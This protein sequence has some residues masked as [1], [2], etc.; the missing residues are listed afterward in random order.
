[1][2]RYLRAS[3]VAATFVSLLA[4]AGPVTAQSGSAIAGVV[5]DSTGA[6]LPGVT[7]EAASPALIEKVRTSV[8]DGQGVFRIVDLRPGTYSV[9]FTLPGFTTVKREGIELTASFTATV[10]ADMR[11]GSLEETITVTGE[12]STVDVQNVVQQRVMTRDVID[13]IPTGYKSVFNL[14]VLVPGVTAFAHDVGGAS[15]TSN[16]IAIHGSRAGETQLLHDG[17]DYSHG[18]GRGGSFTAIATNDATV[19][20]ISLEFGGISAESEMGG[21]RTNIIPKEGGNTFKGTFSG[22]FTNS[23]LQSDNLSDELQAMGLTSTTRT[24]SVYDI[25]PA[26]GGPLA[27]DKVWFF[28]SW[29][30]WASEQTVAGRYFN[31]TPD[32]IPPR[33]TPDLDRPGENNEY[34]RNESLRLT[35]Q[36]TPKNKVSFQ[37]QYGHRDIPGYGY[38]LNRNTASPEAIDANRSIPSYL[39]QLGWNAPL[40]NRVLFEA[41]GALAAKNWR[42]FPQEWV[43]V[44]QPAWRELNDDTRWGNYYGTYGHNA[45]W[46][47][48][49]RLTLSYVTG[50][51]AAKVGISF[52]HTEAHTTQDAVNNARNYDLLNALPSRVTYYATPLSFD[53]V[54]KANVGVFVQDQWSV[55]RWSLNAGLRFDSF[56]A[57]VPE[58]SLEPGPHVPDRYVSFAK[59]ENVPDWKSVSPRLGLSYDLFG[60]GRTA[61]KF[62]LGR[63]MEAPNLTTIT[64]PANPN[65][66]ISTTA[67]RAWVD[68][69]GDFVPQENE[70]GPRSNVNFGNSVVT[71]RYAEDAL[72]TRGYNWETSAAVQHELIARTS[73]NVAYFRRWYGNQRV[74]DNLLLAAADYDPYCITAPVDP[75][76][77][78]GGG[79]QQ[80]G[81]FD[82]KPA[83]FGLLDQSITLSENFGDQRKS[84]TGWTSR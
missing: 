59:V 77:P 17:M 8:S 44:N 58:Q 53:E 63:Y 61:V 13:A 64:G 45:S 37:Y 27:R 39:G 50:S 36:A 62:S 31:L 67:T 48:N 66:S 40:T 79:Y 81:L 23:D 20:E 9:T 5:R 29:R 57:Y 35:W 84:T 33:Y 71:R 11:V 82:V 1:M 46:N 19:Q 22:N 80:C 41:G 15:F 60:N 32:S 78:G 47:V 4:S 28:F 10:N 54:M 16:Q 56:N 55:K 30:K 18:G 52:M 26:I 83:K 21:I 38:S 42:T 76:L 65:R 14:G 74:T 73:V 69:N 24:T 43:D 49:T 70:L 2:H 7:V 3:V 34:N 6:L 72:E 75:R 51:H 25:N 12:A 68:L